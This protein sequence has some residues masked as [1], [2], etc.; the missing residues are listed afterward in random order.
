V[1]DSNRRRKLWDAVER[2]DSRP[3]PKALAFLDAGRQPRGEAR[4]LPAWLV[5][6]GVVTAIVGLAAHALSGPRPMVAFD[7]AILGFWTW[8]CVRRNRMHGGS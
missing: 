2:F 4:K 7:V 3:T 8:Y 5:W 1:T 6:L